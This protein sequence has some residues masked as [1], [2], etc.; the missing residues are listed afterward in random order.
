MEKQTTSK[1]D[2]MWPEIWKD[3][4][5][6][7]QQKEEQQWAIKNKK[8]LDDAGRLPGIYFVDP[9]DAEFKETTKNARRKLE[10]PMPAAM[11]E[12]QEK[13]AQRNLLH[14]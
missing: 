5:E 14:S 8:K 4:S 3:M 11:L 7:A 12:D 2:Y 13:K 10:V 9:E 6:A 1:P